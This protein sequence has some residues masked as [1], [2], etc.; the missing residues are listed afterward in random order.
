M[1][2]GYI[3]LYKEDNLI[4]LYFFKGWTDDNR[5]YYHDLDMS[6]CKYK[7]EKKTYDDGAIDYIFNNEKIRS[8]SCKLI[9]YKLEKEIFMCEL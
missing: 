2:P 3:T 1:L 9:N 4:H 6:N 8:I 5:S 7:F